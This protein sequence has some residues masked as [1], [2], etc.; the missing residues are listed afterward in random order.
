MECNATLAT[1]PYLVAHGLEGVAA[2]DECRSGRLLNGTGM[3]QAGGHAVRRRPMNAAGRQRR[4]R[5]GGG[6]WRGW[7]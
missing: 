2:A 7:G 3:R 5:P 6:G 4:G 1:H